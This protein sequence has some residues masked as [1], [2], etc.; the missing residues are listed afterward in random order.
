MPYDS[1]TPP[2]Y[3]FLMLMPMAGV[4][5]G[6]HVGARERVRVVDELRCLAADLDAGVDAG[7]ET[8]EVAELRVDDHAGREDRLA[9]AQEGV[10]V[11]GRQDDARDH[12]DAEAGAR[13]VE[14]P[15]LGVDR[16]VAQALLRERVDLVVDV[17]RPT[18][19]GRSDRRGPSSTAIGTTTPSSRPKCESLVRPTAPCSDGVM[20]SLTAKRLFLR[21]R[22]ELLR[23]VQHQRLAPPRSS[24]GRTRSRRDR[25]CPTNSG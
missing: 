10:L 20:M 9:L 1:A 2:V 12:R 7:A 18:R 21:R 23:A 5:G 6:A 25:E 14:Q 17:G 4:A 15:D 22:A 24:P 11:A 3:S 19:P 8:A 16:D 13:G